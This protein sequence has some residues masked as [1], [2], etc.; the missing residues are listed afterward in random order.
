VIQKELLVLKELLLLELLAGTASTASRF[1][2]KPHP[3]LK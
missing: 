1:G 2:V 3:D